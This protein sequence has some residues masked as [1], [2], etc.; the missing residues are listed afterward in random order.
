MADLVLDLWV[1]GRPTTK[2][3]VEHIGHGRVRQSVAGSTEWARFLRRAVA[4]TGIGTLGRDV[5]VRV[6]C[7][8]FQPVPRSGPHSSGAPIHER[9]GDSDKLE[10]N[11]LDALTLKKDVKGGVWPDDVQ[12]ISLSSERVYATDS[13]PCGVNVRVWTLSPRD[14]S[15]IG[16]DVQLEAWVAMRRATTGEG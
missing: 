14:V 2:G 15:G 11:V 9:A 7:L 4:D 10:R 12:V 5:P 8:F 6:R 16:I 1:S 13:W 3:S